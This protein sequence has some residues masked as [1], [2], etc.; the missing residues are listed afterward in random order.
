MTGIGVTDSDI[1]PPIIISESGDLWIYKSPDNALRSV[2]AI[3]VRQGLYEAFDS[4]GRALNLVVGPSDE[5]SLQLSNDSAPSER[6]V[7]LLASYV[8]RCIREKPLVADDLRSLI[9]IVLAEGLTDD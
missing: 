8:R 6:L 5:I 3:D 2:E 7:S 4:T 9:G 1:V